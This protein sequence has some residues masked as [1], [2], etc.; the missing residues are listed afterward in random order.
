MSGFVAGNDFDPAAFSIDSP[1]EKSEK[2]SHK[3]T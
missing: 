3:A 1:Q 2:E